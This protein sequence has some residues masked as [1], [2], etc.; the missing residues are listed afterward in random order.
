MCISN[1]G[2]FKLCRTAGKSTCSERVSSVP[3]QIVHLRVCA[4]THQFPNGVFSFM[5]KIN[6][7][8]KNIYCW[9]FFFFS[10]AAEGE[11][12]KQSVCKSDVRLVGK[13]WRSFLSDEISRNDGRDAGT[14]VSG[15]QKAQDT[16]STPLPFLSSVV[17]HQIHQISEKQLIQVQ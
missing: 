9:L 13:Q 17:I 15:D 3:Q 7:T 2:D 11:R 12:K 6:G 1:R 14:T 5:G 10:P 16:Q 4:Q 8:P